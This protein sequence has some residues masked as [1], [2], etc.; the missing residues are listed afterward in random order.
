MNSIGKHIIQQIS[1]NPNQVFSKEE[2]I[3]LVRNATR[4]NSLPI[5]ELDGIKVDPSSFRATKENGEALIFTNKEFSL[6][7]LLISHPERSFRRNEILNEVW[8]TDVVVGDRTIDVHIRKLREKLGDS[9]IVTNKGVGYL[10]SS[11]R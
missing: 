1:Q 9:H 5:V 8:G 7:Y 2:I 3:E 6:L 11:Q 4:I 10:W